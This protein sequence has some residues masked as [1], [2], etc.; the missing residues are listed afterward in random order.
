MDN[1]LENHVQHVFDSY[2][3]KVV[4]NEA[5]DIRREYTRFNKRQMSLE[6][7]TAQELNNLYYYDEY[8]VNH[9]LFLVL[10]LEFLVKDVSKMMAK[11]SKTGEKSR[12]KKLC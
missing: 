8:P 12:F 10:G 5:I 2:C 3:K 11:L 7:I 4:K 1:D 6:N 9:K